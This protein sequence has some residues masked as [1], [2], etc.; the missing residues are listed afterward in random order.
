MTSRR[1]CA[2]RGR[3]SRGAPSLA[4][5]VVQDSARRQ[6]LR[7]RVSREFAVREAG[8]SKL[9]PSMVL[10][11]VE[12]Q[13]RVVHTFDRETSGTVVRTS[14]L[15]IPQ[16]NSGKLRMRRRRALASIPPIRSEVTTQRHAEHTA[17][18]GAPLSLGD[19]DFAEH[20][21][22]KLQLPQTISITIWRAPRPTV[23]R[24]NNAVAFR[25]CQ[26]ERITIERRAGCSR[27][28]VT[29]PLRGQSATLQAH[30]FVPCS[31]LLLATKASQRS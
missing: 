27:H 22:E 13:G 17:I 23:C 24:G 11:R 25:R 21:T 19:D 8:G 1:A 12:H 3:R 7:A 2:G 6:C 18:V 5:E 20:D 31:S 9:A 10:V 30:D 14:A 29:R 26:N 15:R 28:E 4:A 16:S